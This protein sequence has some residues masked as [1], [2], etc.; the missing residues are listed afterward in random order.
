MERTRDQL[1]RALEKQMISRTC[2]NVMGRF[3]LYYTSKRTDDTLALWAKD[4]DTRLELIWGVYD[5]FE[6][7][8]R[9]FSQEIPTH[10]DASARRGNLDIQA[11]ST[12][13][14]E[15]AE[16]TKTA[17]GAWMCQG[18]ETKIVDGEAECN[19]VWTKYGVDFLLEDGKWKIWHMAI[20]GFPPA[21]RLTPSEERQ[22]GIGAGA[23]L[24]S[25]LSGRPASG[26]YGIW[27]SMPVLRVSTTP[28]GHGR[29]NSGL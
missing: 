21:W 1:E 2:Q 28:T 23:N 17:R 8:Q 24:P 22:R 10:K 3:C 16:D 13:V 27:L 18:A 11:L 26:R 7:V 4:P 6:G 19:W 9:R 12:M 15:V 5:G 20:Y 25:T 29:P 14:F